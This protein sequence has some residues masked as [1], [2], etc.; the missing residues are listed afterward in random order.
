MARKP[1]PTDD[2]LNNLPYENFVLWFLEYNSAIIA[3]HISRRLIPNRYDPADVK[4]YM[5][6]RMLDILHKRKKKNKAIQNPRIYFGKL[7]DFWCIEYQRMHGYIYGMPKRPRN[8]AAEEDIAQYGFVYLDTDKSMKSLNGFHES[9]ELAFIDVNLS[10]GDNSYYQ[11]AG[12]QFKGIDPGT[13]SVFWNKLMTNILPE[14]RQVLEC[15]FAMNMSI[16]DVSKH[17]GIA[18]STAYTRRDRGLSTLSGLIVN[19]NINVEQA[20][21]R[22]LNDISQLK[23]SSVDITELL[24]GEF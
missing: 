10:Q 8:V 11:E 5:G 9:P 21:W 24:S 18:I 16:P 3:K 2:E 23:S 7:I 12:Y 1:R 4:A 14:D 20:S 17:L 19:S 15:M 13:P 22:T 6:E